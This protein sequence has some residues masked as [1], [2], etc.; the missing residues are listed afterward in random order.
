MVSRG[1]EEMIPDMPL[2]AQWLGF[3]YEGPPVFFGHYWFTGTPAV[4]SGQFACLDYSAARDGPLMAYRWD[5]ESALSSEK[6]AW[7]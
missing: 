4:C 1:E 6:L 2:P 7:V 3:R 5:G